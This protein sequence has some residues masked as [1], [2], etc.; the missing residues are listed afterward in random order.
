ME[1]ALWLTLVQPDGVK[2]ARAG[3]K[4]LPPIRINADVNAQSIVSREFNVSG[5]LDRGDFNI[6]NMVDIL[7]EGD[8]LFQGAGMD[9][10]ICIPKSERLLSSIWTQG[11]IDKVENHNVA[12]CH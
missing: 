2:V 3:G 4:V 8:C 11:P 1:P 6:D 12:P 7:H 9:M 5:T 10:A